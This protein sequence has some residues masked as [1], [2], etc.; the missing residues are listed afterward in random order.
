MSETVERP[1]I[2]KSGW[3]DGP[4]QGEPDRV[5][6]IHAGF[7]C[8]ALRNPRHGYWCGYVGVP[9]EHPLYGRKWDETPAVGELEAH[10]GVN[11]SAPCGGDI[12]HVPPAGM[13]ADVWWLGFDCGR[14]M[15]LAPGSEARFRELL[16]LKGK[17][18]HPFSF[19]VDDPDSPVREVYRDLPYVRAQIE[20][21]AEQLAGLRG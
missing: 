19:E 2:D 1:V 11:Y 14:A 8:F 17:T 18:Y 15:D 12:C 7:A 13:P 16:A 5:D 20:G 21:L 3:G 6:F 10:R 9:R 4:W